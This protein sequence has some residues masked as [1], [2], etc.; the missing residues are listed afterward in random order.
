MNKIIGK[1][2]WLI[3]ILGVCMIVLTTSIIHNYILFY[4]GIGLLV[5]GII[6]VLVTGEKTKEAI[7]RLLDFI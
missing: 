4:I 2:A 1:V 3:A 7:L 5:I 6:G